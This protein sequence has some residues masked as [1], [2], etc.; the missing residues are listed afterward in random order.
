MQKHKLTPYDEKTESGIIRHVMIKR[1]EATKE[2]LVVIVTP[3]IVFPGRNNLLKDLLKAH[4][5]IKSVIHNI[6]PR[7]TSVILGDQE[8]ILHGK[9]YI[10]DV[11]L[12]KKFQISSKTFYQ[13]NSAQTAK[14]Y[15]KAIELLNPTK[16]DIVLDA[17]AGVGTIGLILS[18]YVKKV[19][20]VEINKDA[21]LSA[22]K[23]ASLNQVSNFSIEQADAKDYILRLKE[24]NVKIDALV[25]DPPRSGLDQS[26][27]DSVL[28]IKP[29]KMVYISCNPETLARD[30]AILNS[31]YEVV[32]VQPLDM[33]SQTYHVE[34]ITLLSLK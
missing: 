17:Y 7:K 4:S 29:K 11:L 24:N 8:K 30:L 3:S 12:G 21:V 6:N 13:I 10:E 1:S 19:M 14:L 2:I 28:T 32:N 23:N 9:G 16:N 18:D 34:S 20:A 27:I 25:V 26:F 22:R 15:K 5:D 33:F 31:V